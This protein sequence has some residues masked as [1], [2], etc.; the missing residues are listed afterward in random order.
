MIAQIRILYPYLFIPREL[1]PCHHSWRN[2]HCEIVAWNYNCIQLHP[3]RVLRIIALNGF[4]LKLHESRSGTFV[5]VLSVYNRL[6][7]DN[8]VINRCCSMRKDKTMYKWY[9]REY[10]FIKSAIC[11]S[12]V[13]T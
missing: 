1:L 5:I 12:F 13:F 7:V 3:V 4:L 2:C 6:V 9:H 8:T 11:E 10:T